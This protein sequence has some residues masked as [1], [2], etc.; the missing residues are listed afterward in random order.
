MSISD[1]RLRRKKSTGT[2]DRKGGLETAPSRRR[3]VAEERINE[4]ER[5]LKCK[6]GRMWR[7]T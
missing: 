1:E 3:L 7:R 2:M 5:A 6:E 4:E